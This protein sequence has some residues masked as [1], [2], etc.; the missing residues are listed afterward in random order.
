MQGVG[1]V[2]TGGESVVKKNGLERSKGR[3]MVEKGGLGSGK[4]RLMRQHNE[5]RA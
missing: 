3:Q 1:W 5:Q 4:R 2:D